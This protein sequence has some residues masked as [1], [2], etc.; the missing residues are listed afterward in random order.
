MSRSKW[1]GPFIQTDLLKKISTIKKKKEIEIFCRNCTITPQFIGLNFKIH[2]G[3]TF[4][5]IKVS[6]SMVGHK[7]G[8]FSSTRKKFSYK[9][10]KN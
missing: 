9:K 4:T 2:T 5:K 8:E 7:F 10:K 3:K 6:E 1:K